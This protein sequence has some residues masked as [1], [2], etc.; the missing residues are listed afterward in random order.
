VLKAQLHSRTPRN[1]VI[2][3]LLLTSLLA[4]PAASAANLQF[5]VHQSDQFA[6]AGHTYS[7]AKMTA[8][9]VLYLYSRDPLVVLKKPANEPPAVISLS[10]LPN[11]APYQLLNDFAVDAQGALYVPA[12]WKDASRV[13]HSGV[14]VLDPDGRYQRTVEFAV[15]V[16]TRHIAVDETGNLFVLGIDG[17]YYRGKT[18]DDSLLHKF[19][20]TGAHVRAFSPAVMPL[21][22]GEVFQR[23]KRD[24][25]KGLLVFGPDGLLYSVMAESGALRIFDSDG[26]LVKETRLIQPEARDQW[27]W[28][29]VPLPGNRYLVHWVHSDISGSVMTNRPYLALHNGSGEVIAGPARQPWSRSYPIAADR[30][31]NCYF[32]HDLG[33]GTQELVT[34]TVSVR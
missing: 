27:I 1:L 24:I 22:S 14:F 13:L 26:T 17:R 21:A 34:T 23:A 10:G 12:L 33:E 11:L 31:A 20:S 9:G 30:D 8:D 6:L 3:L 7:A 16:E 15:P 4:P 32:L 29:F 2:L 25:D 19:N 5:V 28:H 18:T